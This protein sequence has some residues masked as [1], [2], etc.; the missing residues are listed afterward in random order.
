[1]YISFGNRKKDSFQ[2]N[3]KIRAV[4]SESSLLLTLNFLVAYAQAGPSICC[5]PVQYGSFVPFASPFLSR[6]E[7]DQLLYLEFKTQYAH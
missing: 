6:I 4:R 7:A 2:R 3:N 1:M 5:S